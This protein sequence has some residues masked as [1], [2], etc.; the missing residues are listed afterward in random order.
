MTSVGL[1]FEYLTKGD[2]IVY[3]IDRIWVEIGNVNEGRKHIVRRCW[4]FAYSRFNTGRPLDNGWN[5][6]PALVKVLLK[7]A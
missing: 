6:E 5:S 2:A 1:A 4:E 3:P 7:T